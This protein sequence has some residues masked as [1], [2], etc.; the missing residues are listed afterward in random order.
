MI[1]DVLA[2][3][4]PLFNDK[5]EHD[6]Y[7]LRGTIYNIMGNFQR[8]LYDFTVAIRIANSCGDKDVTTKLIAEYINMAGV[9]H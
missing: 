7:A 3:I 1:S 9:Q 6:A 4:A 5:D 2:K 8:A